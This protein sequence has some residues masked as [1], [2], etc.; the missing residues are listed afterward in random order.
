MN[1]G[2]DRAKVYPLFFGMVAG[3]TKWLRFGKR[4]RPLAVAAKRRERS[5]IPRWRTARWFRSVAAKARD[6]SLALAA[7]M[8]MWSAIALDSAP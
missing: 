1:L 2:W 7:R 5:L 8:G 6:H 4:D 3:V